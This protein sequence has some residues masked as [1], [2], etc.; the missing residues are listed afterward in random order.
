MACSP[1]GPAD[2]RTGRSGGDFAGTDC[3]VTTRSDAFSDDAS[4]TR[5]TL[6][7]VMVSFTPLSSSMRSTSLSPAGSTET[8]VP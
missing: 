8:T 5:I 2:G 4:S 1:A 6:D 7:R 3:G